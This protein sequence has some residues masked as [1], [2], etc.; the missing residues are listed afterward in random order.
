[1]TKFLNLFYRKLN[2]QFKIHLKT[3]ILRKLVYFK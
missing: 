1:M 2:M 3:K